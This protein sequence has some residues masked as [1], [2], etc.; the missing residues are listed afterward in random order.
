MNGNMEVKVLGTSFNACGYNGEGNTDVILKNGSVQIADKASGESVILKPNQRFTKKD[1]KTEVSYVRAEECC[2]WFE[3]DIAFDNVALRDILETI[4]HRYRI[5]IKAN[6]GSLAD[7][8]MSLT[9]KDEPLE[10]V[11]D[12]LGALLPVDWSIREKDLY[13]ER[14]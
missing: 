3:K 2:R 7:K 13:L 14:K 9:I 12:I 8:R 6:L 5:G 10:D 11:M 4:S 1:G